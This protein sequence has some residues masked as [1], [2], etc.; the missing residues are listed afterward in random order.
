M[1]RCERTRDFSFFVHVFNNVYKNI[2][3]SL[4][5]FDKLTSGMGKGGGGG[6]GLRVWK[7]SPIIPLVGP[8]FLMFNLIYQGPLLDGS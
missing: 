5:I 6:G 2:T 7:F 4:T 1:K 8:I 3:K